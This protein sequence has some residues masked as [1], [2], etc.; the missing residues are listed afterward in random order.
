VRSG[1]PHQRSPCWKGLCDDCPIAR[2]HVQSAVVIPVA[3]AEPLVSSWRRRFDAS[4]VRGMPAH[5]TA[6]APF[7]PPKRLSEGVLAE[8]A[9]LCAARPVLDVEFRRTNRFPGVLYLDPE[10]A[11]GLRE[12]TDAIAR[13]W[14]EAPPYGGAFEQVTPHLTIA[15][16]AGDE[17]FAAIER[18]LGERLPLRAHLREACLYVD[19]GAHWRLLRR[20]PFGAGERER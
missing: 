14:P 2:E 10:P 13:A 19:D 6:H 5:V 18:A 12:L 17:T 16:G 3:E 9:V 7:L 15:H 1:P 11:E 8:L 20:L 4:A